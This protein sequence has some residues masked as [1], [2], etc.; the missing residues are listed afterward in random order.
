MK[1]LY[2]DIRNPLT[3]ILVKEAE[4]L[5]QAGKRVFYIAPNSLSFEKERAVLS[6]LENHASFAITVTRFAQMAR[7]F[8]LNDVQQGKPLDDI[9]LGMLFYKVL[10]EMEEHD[11][12]VYGGI[13]TDA[14]FIQQLVELYHE[15]QEAKMT[16]ADLDSLDEAEKKADLINILQLV[17]HQLNQ[18]EFTSESNIMV[19]ANHIIAGDVDAELQNLVLVID[20][21]TRFSAE[22]AYLIEL[23]HSKG[24][25]IV[26]GA[27]A[28]EKAYRA[29][30]REGNLYQASVDFLRHLADEYKVKPEYRPAIQPDDAFGNISKLLES[31]YDFSDVELELTE[32]DRSHVQIWS[33]VNQKEELEYV[34]KSIRQR[35]HDGAR[36]KDIRVLLGDV[37]VYRLQ[38]KTIFD[39]YQIPFYLGRSEA[40]AHHPLVQFIEA[41][42]RLKHYNFRTEDLLNLVKTGLYGHLKQEELDL[43]EQYIRFADVKGASKFAKGFTHN[44][45][46]KFDLIHIN[47]LRKKIVTPLLEFFK[48]RSQ[49]ATGLLQKF[50]QFLTT[51]SF[52]QNFAGLVDFTN[53]QDQ[54]RQEEVWKAFCHVL[55][56]FASVFSASKVKL[57]DFLTLVQSGMLL[58]NYRTIPATVDV[59]TVQ[60]YDLIEP[61]SSPFVYAVGLTQDYFP[62][63]VQNKSLLS[64]EER[65]RLNEAT[66]ERS[67]LL[68]AAQENL[69]KNRF[70]ALSLLNAAMDR[71]VL[72][73][74]QIVN[75]IE[76][77]ISP[78]L[79][80]LHEQPIGLPI[81]VKRSQATS[82]DIGTYRALLA[83]VIELNQGDIDRE[84]SLTEKEQTFWSVAVRVLRKKLES[85]GI[86]IPNVT[87]SLTTETLSEQTLQ[88][89]YPPHQAFLLSTSALTEFY[90]N[91]YAYFLKYVLALQEEMTIHPDARSHGNFLHRVFEKVMQ[92]QSSE[93][94]D[95]RLEKAIQEA[96]QEAEFEALYTENAEALFAHE[97]LLDTAR[98]TGRVLERNDLVE[99]IQE[100]AV[101]GQEETN[102]LTLSDGRNLQIRGKVDRIDRLKIDG[103]LGVV[104]Y[105]SSDTNFDFQKFFNG[106]NSQLPT[107]LAALKQE[108]WMNEEAHAFGA[109]Y[110]QMTN[111]LVP[112]AKT[113]SQGDAVKEAMKNLEY[114]GLFLFEQARQLNGL[115]D[116]KKVN[117]LSQEELETLLA[118]NAL[119]YRRAAEQ[120][121][122]GHFYIN[123]YTENGRS[124]APFVEQY[125]SITGFEANLHLSS[126]RHLVKL[127]SHPIGEKK[128]QAW[129]EKMKEELEK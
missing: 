19:F 77:N 98:A 93:P 73:T 92:E 67:E 111:P 90:R 42:V 105:K 21:F 72:S 85:E 124:I 15:L 39:Q 129:I 53:P 107:Y 99:T 119:L 126:A 11:L 32:Q 62:K 79:L 101:F 102:V 95:N 97:V 128:R 78:Y 14:Q 127:D 63:I 38:L 6:L 81:E 31:R 61:L 60:S 40:M 83:R 47:Q 34:A 89:L 108:S 22:E 30:F 28:S 17:T 64:D 58:S 71:L 12:Q 4:R 27:Y 18:S 36:Y 1:L 52:S 2:T 3:K 56:Q 114:K 123:P 23:L 33:A 44:Q 88:A 57:D 13:R 76:N 110:L 16:V 109:M 75:E 20:G 66:D 118:Y 45:H 94:F 117:L 8:V 103:S 65:L 35:V 106:L 54:E 26:I 5:A 70:V 37:E 104:D 82:D 125:K 55:E 120:I 9:G 59:V 24:V 91:Q 122:A 25:E 68:I 80:E 46:Q 43:F 87:S 96:S 49:T 29:S 86:S 10:S 84:R 100:E 48:S 74:P 115:Y 116:K 113:K 50:H 112:L 69:Q 121:L 51:I 41:L 7:Y